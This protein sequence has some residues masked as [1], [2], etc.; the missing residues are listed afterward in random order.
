MKRI[1]LLSFAIA[2][3]AYSCNSSETSQEV[4]LQA[5][6][7]TKEQTAPSQPEQILTSNEL[8]T[9]VLLKG[10]I[11]SP[12]KE[13]RAKI[14]EE[15]LT[16]NYGSPSINQREVWGNIVQFDKVWRT[17]ANEATTFETSAD[18]K[19]QGQDLPAGKY[20]L[21][22]IPKKEGDWTVIFNSTWEQWGAYKYDAS[23]DVLRVKVTPV[24]RE[25][26][27]ETMDF[28]MNDNHL[29]LQWEMLALPIKI[30]E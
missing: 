28:V 14:G 10:D 22:T 18:L 20:G 1:Y 2:L 8:Y 25:E 30:G 24:M 5:A 6:E 26:S 15:T 19:I 16:V 12:M 13:M 3:F 21:F 4:T 27:V 7:E 11:P 23:K 29:V 9:T 17:G